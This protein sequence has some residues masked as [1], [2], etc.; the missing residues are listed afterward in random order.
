M[1]SGWKDLIFWISYGIKTVFRDEIKRETFKQPTFRFY[2]PITGSKWM[3]YLFPSSFLVILKF[4][5]DLIIHN[6]TR[7]QDFCLLV[8]AFVSLDKQS[9]SLTIVLKQ[10]GENFDFAVN[11]LRGEISFELT[12]DGS[13]LYHRFRAWV[14]NEIL[15]K[16]D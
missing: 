10:G 14:G 16:R 13:P 6:K 9:T 7:Y 8:F 3:A 12:R 2:Q 4:E 1:A 15:R 5:T 11:I